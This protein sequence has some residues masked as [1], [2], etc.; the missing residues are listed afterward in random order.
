[1]AAQVGAAPTSDASEAR[2]LETPRPAADRWAI[3]GPIRLGSEPSSLEGEN[4]IK[5]I[6]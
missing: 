3:K 6:K 1:M 2:V 4:S 5:D